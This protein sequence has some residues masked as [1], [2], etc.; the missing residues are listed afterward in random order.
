MI[1]LNAPR[2]L[3]RADALLNSRCLPGPNRKGLPRAYPL[4]R[5][6]VLLC[7]NPVV[8]EGGIQ[9]SLTPRGARGVISSSS[10]GDIVRG[11]GT[12]RWWTKFGATGSCLVRIFILN[13]TRSKI[14]LTI[15]SIILAID[16]CQLDTK[17]LFVTYLVWQ[18]P[19]R[20][21]NCRQAWLLP[22]N[23][24]LKWYSSKDLS[25]DRVDNIRYRK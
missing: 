24:R 1:A 4:Q 21:Y 18:Y 3:P 13:G 7:R 2:D 5:E 8:R 14:Y 16:D 6:R 10:Y 23:F 20:S 19:M 17:V 15:G 11:T 12:V 9:E 22:V 25:S